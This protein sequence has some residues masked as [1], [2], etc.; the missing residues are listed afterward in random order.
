MFFLLSWRTYTPPWARYAEVVLTRYSVHSEG[1][2][3]SSLGTLRVELHSFA[4]ETSADELHW[5]E[6]TPRARTVTEGSG[7]L[8]VEHIYATLGTVRGGRPDPLRRPFGRCEIQRPGA[9]F[10]MLHEPGRRRAPEP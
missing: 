3:S 5:A 7:P 1:A 2:K 6:V 10:I 8:L 9:H 4:I